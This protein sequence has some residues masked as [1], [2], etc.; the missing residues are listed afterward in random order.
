MFVV[1]SRQASAGIR[2]QAE[3][4]TIL[5]AL[6]RGGYRLAMREMYSGLRQSVSPGSTEETASLLASQAAKFGRR[7]SMQMRPVVGEILFKDSHAFIIVPDVTRLICYNVRHSQ[8][9]TAIEDF[10]AAVESA[11]R[12]G[13]DGRR[14]RGMSFAWR[15]VAKDPQF[16]AMAGARLRR[17]P[18]RSLSASISDVREMKPEYGEPQRAGASL[19]VEEGARTFLLQLAQVTRAL[20]TDTGPLGS[21]AD[22]GR[23]LDTGLIRRE[24]L[25]SC[26]QDSHTLCTLPSRDIL[27]NAAGSQIKCPVC[28]R[29]YADELIRD[30]Y[31]LTDLARELLDGSRWMQIWITEL[32]CRNGVPREQIR[33]NVGATGEDL[34]VKVDVFGHT[35]FFELK[36]RDFG[37]GDAY[38]F[39]MRV[40]RYA[41][42]FGIVA[43]TGRVAE[44]AR[45]LFEEQNKQ[46][47]EIRGASISWLEAAE[48]V[49]RGIG[50]QLETI[51]RSHVAMLV[52]AFSDAVGLDLW[53][54]FARWLDTVVA[55]VP[56]A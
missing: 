49:S 53:P 50:E 8:V 46:P 19:L 31:V 29:G 56:D 44:D 34:D 24:Y 40:N 17:V 39:T 11:T 20:T 5:D 13:L 23:L 9:E 15:P 48:G 32:L 36:D 12:I 28:R 35:V 6:A 3:M 52:Q 25:F 47:Q 33:W 1:D 51:S 38:P 10:C 37:L 30:I 43:T 42:E 2:E 21:E 22:V 18:R 45:N 7:Y 4:E 41:G 27:A 54:A 26:R 16:I 55:D 14:V